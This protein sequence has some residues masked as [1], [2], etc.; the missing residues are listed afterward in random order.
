M[1]VKSFVAKGMAKEKHRK[2]K[3]IISI[4]LPNM[5]DLNLHSLLL[6]FIHVAHNYK[7]VFT[8]GRLSKVVRHTFRSK[9]LLMVT[10]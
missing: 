2:Y 9:R 8:I 4:H 5:Y 6:V 7:D 1:V 10:D 3:H